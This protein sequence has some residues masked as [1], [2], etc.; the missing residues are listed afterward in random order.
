LKSQ[1]VYKENRGEAYMLAATLSHERQ[2]FAVRGGYEDVM[3]YAMTKRVP[4]YESHVKL[5]L[6]NADTTEI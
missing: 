1:N 3:L 6:K 2:R 4:K 5:F